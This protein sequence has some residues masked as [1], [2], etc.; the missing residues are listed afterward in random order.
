MSES[1]AKPTHWDGRRQD[2]KTARNDGRLVVVPAP[3]AGGGPFT[4]RSERGRFCENGSDRYDPRPHDQNAMNGETTRSLAI[5]GVLLP[6]TIIEPD[7]HVP[8]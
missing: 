5:H 2:G 4:V 1:H 6:A 8:G 3:V 7:S